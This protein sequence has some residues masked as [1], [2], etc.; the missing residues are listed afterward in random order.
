MI[1]YDPANPMPAFEQLRGQLAAK[2]RTGALTA[3]TRLPTI[4]QLAADLDLA[5]GTVARAYS[6][7]E[8]EGLVVAR[9]GA[10]TV[11]AVQDRQFDLVVD[12]AVDFTLVAQKNGL[13]VDE[14]VLAVRAAWM[15]ESRGPA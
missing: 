12:A 1:E 8:R 4:R 15:A 9:R 6:Q 7:L 2:I 10:G 11:V 14:A 5:P 13:T 3:G